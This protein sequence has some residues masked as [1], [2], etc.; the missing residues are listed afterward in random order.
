[1]MRLSERP[2]VKF[3]NIAPE[4]PMRC[5]RC[6]SLMA[7]EKHYGLQDYFWGWRC[8]YCGDIIDRIILENRAWM[9]TGPLR[10]R[11]GSSNQRG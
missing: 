8:I 5:Y 4:G 1:M 11:V 2:A 7:Y 9:P 10:Q 6:G 3:N